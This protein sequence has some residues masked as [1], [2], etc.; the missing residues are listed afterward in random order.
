MTTDRGPERLGR[1]LDRLLGSLRA[2]TTDVLDT[3]FSRWAEIVG[4]DVAAHARPIAV[5]GSTLTVEADDPAW[6][7]E[8]RWLENEV[9]ARLAE[10]A[11]TDRISRVF[12]RVARRK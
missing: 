2:P 6:A 3:V 4:P 9:V 1:V 11:G 7:S 12:V 5:E 8:L 10:V